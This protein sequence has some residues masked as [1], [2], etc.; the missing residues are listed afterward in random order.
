MGQKI[1]GAAKRNFFTLIELLMVVAVIALLAAILLPALQAAKE[2]GQRTICFSNLRQCAIGWLNYGADYDGRIRLTY[3]DN[4][5]WTYSPNTCWPR[6]MMTETK[7]LKR[8]VMGDPYSKPRYADIPVAWNEGYDNNEI[9]YSGWG[10]KYDWQGFYGMPQPEWYFGCVT[11]TYGGGGAH[12]LYL[13]RVRQA[14]NFFILGDSLEWYNGPGYQQT[15]P[16][17][18]GHDARYLWRIHKNAANVVM[19]D[20]HAV[21]GKQAFLSQMSYADLTVSKTSSP[22]C[23]SYDKDGN[24]SYLSMP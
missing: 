23:R 1:S 7:Y 13:S 22:F 2:A 5:A 4:S 15:K 14:S 24:L 9:F 19:L 16:A 10:K 17:I 18:V 3:A 20:G 11:G 6:M 12:M 8:K 21:L